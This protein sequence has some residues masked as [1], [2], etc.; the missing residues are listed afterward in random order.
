MSAK[1][2]SNIMLVIPVKE[3]DKDGKA[4]TAV[5]ARTREAKR[6]LK[7]MLYGGQDAEGIRW[8]ALL[9]SKDDRKVVQGFSW[10]SS[11]THT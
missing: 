7:A 2:V 8:R 9:C 5:D 10:K 6:V 3:T 11:P 4:Y 1:V